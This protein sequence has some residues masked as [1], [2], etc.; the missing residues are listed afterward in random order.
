M[1]AG[2]ARWLGF[3]GAD[4]VRKRGTETATWAALASFIERGH[5]DD[6]YEY[7]N[8]LYCRNWLH[9]AWRLL[10]ERN[11]QPWAP[12]DQIPGRPVKGRDSGR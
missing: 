7:T 10:D 2:K 4:P 6:T 8:D 12:A 9:E 3:D 5:G 1:R 11:L